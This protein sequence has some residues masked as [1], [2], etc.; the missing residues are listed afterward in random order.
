M[1][2]DE[3]SLFLLSVSRAIRADSLRIVIV[4]SNVIR[5]A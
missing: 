5:F 4:I 2:S 3:R 1:V